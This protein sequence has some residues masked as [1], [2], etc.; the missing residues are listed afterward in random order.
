MCECH[1]L[2]A[3]ISGGR[4]G[5]KR[6][7]DKRKGKKKKKKMCPDTSAIRYGGGTTSTNAT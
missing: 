1:F 6:K 4:K 3:D 2:L 7:E 5:E